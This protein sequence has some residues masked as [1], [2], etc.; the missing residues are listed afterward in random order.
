M[1]QSRVPVRFVISLLVSLVCACRDQGK[2]SSP[3]VTSTVNL[4]QYDTADLTVDENSFCA[5]ARTNRDDAA[6]CAML[7]Q[8]RTPLSK[9]ILAFQ[10]KQ[11][12]ALYEFPVFTGGTESGTASERVYSSRIAVGPFETLADCQLA[13]EAARSQSLDTGPCRQA[14]L[15]RVP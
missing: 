6:M 12:G 4:V 10:S 2:P 13:L 8:L 3:L 11:Q 1:R 9:G 14:E 7:R 15:P 5:P